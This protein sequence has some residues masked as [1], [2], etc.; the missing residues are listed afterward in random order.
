MPT[1]PIIARTNLSQLQ[2]GDILSTL[3][4]GGVGS[5]N[6]TAIIIR[7][8]ASTF[9]GFDATGMVGLYNYSE[10]NLPVVANKAVIAIANNTATDV[11]TVTVQNTAAPQNN[12]LRVNLV[13]E[14]GGGGTVGQGEATAGISY[15]FAIVRIGGAV[16]VIGASSAYGSATAVSA[17][18]ATITLTAAASAVTGGATVTNTFTIQATIAR[19]SGSSQNHVCDV[20]ATLIG[21]NIGGITVV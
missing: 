19:G 15:D 17:G 9:V 2:Y 6:T 8:T 20:T 13:G 16:T 12:V 21:P 1:N 10:L 7:P 5:P 11:L 14:L 18:A 3:S 4:T